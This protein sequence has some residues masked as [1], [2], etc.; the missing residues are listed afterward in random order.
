MAQYAVVENGQVTELYD[1][2]P[3]SWRNI[4]GL[5]LMTDAERESVG[6]FVVTQSSVQYDP[7]RDNLITNEVALDEN[8]R[9]Y[10]NLAVEPKM[11][12]SEWNTFKI[13][14]ALDILRMKRN[15]LLSNCDWT[16]APDLVTLYGQT[17]VDNWKT[18]RQQL[19]DL[20]NTYKN[21]TTIFDPE[22]V[23]FPSKPN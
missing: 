2:I 13:N 18:Y 15:S 9:P 22:S 10:M 1:H 19:R 23:I 12:S 20:T 3:S 5:D 16:M 6:F 7:R 14:E 11:S 21:T 8:G 4:S 17:W